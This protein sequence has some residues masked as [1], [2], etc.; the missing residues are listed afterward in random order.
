MPSEREQK[1]ISPKGLITIPEPYR[2]YYGIVEGD[3]IVVK[4]DKFVWAIPKKIFDQITKVEN[5]LINSTLTK[6][7]TED[8]ILMLSE[9][10]NRKEKENLIL[11][12]WGKLTY[13]E[14]QDLLKLMT[15]IKELVGS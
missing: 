3:D 1:V 12:I 13:P 9:E 6:V 2:T 5:I 4:W 8:I 15:G 10:M 14:Q 11:M 7:P